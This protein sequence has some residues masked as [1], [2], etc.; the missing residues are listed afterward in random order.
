MQKCRTCLIAQSFF[1]CYQ[2]LLASQSRPFQNGNM[3]FS[4][5][6]LT[7]SG[8]ELQEN[9]ALRHRIQTLE[10]EDD[11]RMDQLRADGLAQAQLWD[12]ERTRLEDEIRMARESAEHERNMNTKMKLHMSSLEEELRAGAAF[13]VVSAGQRDDIARLEQMLLIAES[14]RDRGG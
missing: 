13:G 12:R 8:W 9:A 14:D 2:R 1:N 7:G 11:A 6:L 4:R 10:M 3:S 5:F